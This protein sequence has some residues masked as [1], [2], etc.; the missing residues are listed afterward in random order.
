VITIRMNDL[1]LE[2]ATQQAAQHIEKDTEQR[3]G[4]NEAEQE[5]DDFLDPRCVLRVIE[6]FFDN[7]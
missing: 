3:T 2:G 4:K 6:A 1:E 5:E 7:V